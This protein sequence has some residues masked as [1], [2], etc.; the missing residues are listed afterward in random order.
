MSPVETGSTVAVV[1]WAFCSYHFGVGRSWK[2]PLKDHYLLLF[3][4]A[5][6]CV[7]SLPRKMFLIIQS[8]RGRVLDRTLD[9]PLCSVIRWA[10]FDC[11]WSVTSV[12]AAVPERWNVRAVSQ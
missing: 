10:V 5:P 3:A 7:K 4:F 6:P 2:N 11:V 12:P 1:S 9:P 8:P